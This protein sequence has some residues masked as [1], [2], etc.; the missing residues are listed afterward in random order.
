MPLDIQLET[1]YLSITRSSKTFIIKQIFSN[2][3]YI[4]LKWMDMYRGNAD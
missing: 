1:F 3:I 2:N 4:Y